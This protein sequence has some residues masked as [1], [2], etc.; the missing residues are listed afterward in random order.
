MAYRLATRIGATLERRPVTAFAIFTIVFFATTIV[1]ARAKPFWHDEIYTI[2]FSRLSSIS[3]MWAAA[4]DG[5]DLAPPLNT[6]L[7][8]AVG[9]IAGVGPVAT[10]LPPMLGFWIAALVVFDL[11]RRRSSVTLGLAA[12]LVPCFTAAYR[13]AYEARGYGLAVGLFALAVYSWSH[14]AAGRRRALHIPLLAVWLIAGIWNHYFAVVTLIPIGLGE[15]TRLASRRRADWPVYAAFATVLIGVL[16]LRH[17]VAANSAQSASFWQHVDPSDVGSTYW[18]LL[19]PMLEPRFAVVSG[20][21]AVALAS[22][23][24]RRVRIPQGQ[25]RVPAHEVAAGIGAALIPLF[26]VVMAM[27]LTGV[28]VPRYALS[29]SVGIALVVPLSVW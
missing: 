7:T 28:F 12:A 21:L 22:D 26:G 13:Y 23:V 25:W 24:W 14:A 17:L 9:A 1:R 8:R 15:L 20:V 18:F 11:V 6:V 19:E 16:P 2:L 27:L 3:S 5:I 4:R 10:R 29:A